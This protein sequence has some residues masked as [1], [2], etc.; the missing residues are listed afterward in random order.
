[1]DRDVQE[2][3][4]A[5]EL[6][7]LHVLAEAPVR[8]E[9]ALLE[10][11]RAVVLAL[12]VEGLAQAVEDLGAVTELAGLLETGARGLPVGRGKRFPASA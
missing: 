9:R 5:R 7:R 3:Q 6:R 2:P 10:L 1:V 12:K 8:R 11:D 4:P